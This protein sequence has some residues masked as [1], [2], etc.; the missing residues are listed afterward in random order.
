MQLVPRIAI[1]RND[2]NIALYQYDRIEVGL[3]L[4][5]SFR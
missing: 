2:S 3:T 1:Y 4:R 5:R